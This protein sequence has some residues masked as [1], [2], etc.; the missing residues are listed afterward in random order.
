MQPQRDHAQDSIRLHCLLCG[1]WRCIPAL[2]RAQ[3][4][5]NTILHCLVD[6]ILGVQ[7]GVQ[8][9]SAGDSLQHR[10]PPSHCCSVLQGADGKWKHKVAVSQEWTKVCTPCVVPSLYALIR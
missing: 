2:H 6:F 3:L 8:S 1:L 7:P 9:A 10:W 4:Q 5:A